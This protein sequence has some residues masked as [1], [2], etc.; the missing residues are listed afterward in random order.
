MAFYNTKFN[1][2][3]YD[4][5]VLLIGLYSFTTLTQSLY[6][7]SANRIVVACIAVLILVSKSK[8]KIRSFIISV[9]STSVIFFHYT[10]TKFPKQFK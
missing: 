7:V 1:F 8:K 6:P 10:S 9:F 3:K 2:N 5:I 4:V